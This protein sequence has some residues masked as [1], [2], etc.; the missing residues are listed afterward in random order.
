MKSFIVQNEIKNNINSI[1]ILYLENERILTQLKQHK[2][3]FNF[4]IGDTKKEYKK[5]CNLVQCKALLPLYDD[6]INGNRNQ[7]KV[8]VKVR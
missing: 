8:K 4:N 3:S 2:L 7:I 6:F 5:L 1:K